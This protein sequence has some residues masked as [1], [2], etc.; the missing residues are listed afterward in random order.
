[1]AGLFDTLVSYPTA[2]WTALLGVVLI[3]WVLAIIGIVDFE[4]SGIDVDLDTDT[5]LHADGA[6]LGAIA[7]Y[8]VAFGLNGVPFSI[9]VSLIVLIGWFLT[10]MF[11]IYVLAW[12]PTAFLK[13]IVGTGAFIASFMLA[14]PFTARIVRPMRGLFVTHVARSNHSLIGQTCKVLTLEV[15][16]KFGRAEVAERGAGLNIRIWAKSPNTLTKGS[17]A[18]IVEYDEAGTRYLVEP[19]TEI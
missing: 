9:V 18:R 6:D 1:M 15:T 12:V 3:Y 10:G 16:E 4:S 11:S 5:D 2:I 14:I 13:A 8:V 17:L 7:S 19:E